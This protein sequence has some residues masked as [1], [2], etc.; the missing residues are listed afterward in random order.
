MKQI[1]FTNFRKFQDFPAMD[2]G[3]ITILVGGNNAGKSTVVKAML[4]IAD[5]M[6]STYFDNN[7]DPTSILNQRFYF[8]KNYYAHI[9]TVSRALHKQAEGNK[10]MNLF[11]N[12]GDYSIDLTLFQDDDD[13]N[14]TSAFI[15]KIVLKDFPRQIDYNIDFPKDSLVVTFA[16]SSDMVKPSEE[17]INAEQELKELRMHLKTEKDVD[18]KAQL[19]DRIRDLSG[20]LRYVKKQNKAVTEPY[21]I[22]TTI[23]GYRGM[24]G[25]PL[26]PLLL[27]RLVG[28]SEYFDSEGNPKTNKFTKDKNFNLSKNDIAF[29]I[30]NEDSIRSSLHSFDG[31]FMWSRQYEYIYAHSANQMIIYNSKDSNDYLVKTIHEFASMRIKP[32]DHANRFIKEWMQKFEI[33]ID[34]KLKSV[35]GEAHTL[36]IIDEN[37]N[38]VYLADKGMGSIQ[39]MILLL[40]LAT[41]IGNGRMMPSRVIT[42]MVEEPEQNLHPQLQ[43]K[44][45]DLFVYLNKKYG[46][47]FIIETHSEYLVRKAQVIVGDQ[48]YKTQKELN[49]DNPF[50]VYYFPQNTRPYEMVFTPSG[51][52]E[53]DFDSGFFDEATRHQLKLLQNKRKL[54]NV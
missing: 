12:M 34:Y 24:V 13:E 7:E 3:D 26:L 9:G 17:Q 10:E 51:L 50:K 5:F 49:E 29:L 2:L 54:G 30:K 19:K 4:L 14:A 21:T 28:L 47:K 42:I 45:A 20:Y 1:G 43:S 23:T 36:E 39:L 46:F 18:K 38:K 52:F 31:Y 35:G 44:L 6:Q 11:V 22:N 32:G 25:G 40:R 16:P 41:L 33:G 27:Y 48:G 37:K 53:N 15:R 8:D